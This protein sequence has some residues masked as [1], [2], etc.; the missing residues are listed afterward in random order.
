MN[1]KQIRQSFKL[2]LQ[3][4]FTF[5]GEVRLDDI[6]IYQEKGYSSQP[7]SLGFEKAGI[8]AVLKDYT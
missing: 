4:H 7:E 6:Q 1:Q 3:N 5:H 2:Y 8:L